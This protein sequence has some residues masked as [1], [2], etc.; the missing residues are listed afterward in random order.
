VEQTIDDALER[1]SVPQ[2]ARPVLVTTLQ[3]LLAAGFEA[4]LPR[5]TGLMSSSRDKPRDEPRSDLPKAA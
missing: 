2:E 4:V 3:L 5:L 1:G